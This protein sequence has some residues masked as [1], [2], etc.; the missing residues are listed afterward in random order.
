[1]SSLLLVRFTVRS[2]RVTN[3]W[4]FLLCE[5][6]YNIVQDAQQSRCSATLISH[7]WHTITFGKI[8][9]AYRVIFWRVELYSLLWGKFATAS[10]CGHILPVFQEVGRRQMYAI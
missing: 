10:F 5:T 4:H 1:V 6:A 8:L 3:E 7:L 9:D 2:D